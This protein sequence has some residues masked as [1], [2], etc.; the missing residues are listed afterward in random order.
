MSDGSDLS[1][2]FGNN[3][4]QPVC[5]AEPIV[6]SRERLSLAYRSCVSQHLR[7]ESALSQSIPPKVIAPASLSKRTAIAA[8]VLHISPYRAFRIA[9]ECACQV[10]D[11][12][13]PDHATATPI[14]S[15]LS[16]DESA[17]NA[18]A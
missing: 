17:S 15:E 1:G 18:P 10:R 13:I 11:S 2:E 3:A 9:T 5:I 14:S 6:G 7:E 16:C 4:D 12:S 8:L